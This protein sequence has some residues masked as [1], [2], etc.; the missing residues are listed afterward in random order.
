MTKPTL[1]KP[2]K[3]SPS[4]FLSASIN[5]TDTVI[6]VA[7]SAIFQTESPAVTRLTLG[8]DET[9]T[10][11]VTVVAYLTSNQIQVLRGTPAYSWDSGTNVARV[12]TAADLNDVHQYLD[13]LDDISI[14]NGQDHNHST[15]DET[16]IPAAGIGAD[17]INSSKIADNAVNTE[18]IVADAVNGAKIADDSIDSEHIV[19]GSIDKVHLAADVIDGTKLADDAVNS[20]HIAD[21]AI[22]TVHIG[23][24]QVTATKIAA[25]AING[26]KIADDSIDSEHIVDGAVDAVHLSKNAAGK[27]TVY[28]RVLLT[29]ELLASGN[30]LDYFTVPVSLNGHILSDFDIAIYGVSSSGIVSAQLHNLTDAVDMLSTN[31]TIDV[32][33]YSSYTAETPPVI[34]QAHDDVVTGDRLRMDIDNPGTGVLGFEVIMIFEVP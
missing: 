23:P 3:D 21:G 10:E 24:L 25:D 2:Q 28:W 8:Y 31:A 16:P 22:D 11:T 32:G 30:G 5:E 9:T 7:S 20:E 19:D 13:Y 4:T 1:H 14:P 12:F 15:V 18:H 33:E 27:K 26:T 34:D 17:A 6:T 29:D